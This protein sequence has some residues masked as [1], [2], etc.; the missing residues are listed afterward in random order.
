MQ[1]QFRAIENA[2]ISLILCS[3]LVGGCNA[4]QGSGGVPTPEE[5]CSS[6]T[7]YDALT[8]ILSTQAQSA[9]SVLG[10]DPQL[11]TAASPASLKAVLSYAS[12]TVED[13]NAGTGKVGCKALLRLDTPT[14]ALAQ[15]PG[16]SPN[17]FGP[18]H[19]TYA[20]SYTVQKTADRGQPLMTLENAGSLAAVAFQASIT[21]LRRG[22]D[23]TAQ[24]PVA[25]DDTAIEDDRGAEDPEP[26]AEQ[27][28]AALDRANA[29]EPAANSDSAAPP[30]ASPSE[31][32]PQ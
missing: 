11:T 14:T 13:I 25:D 28:Q 6:Q 10:N 29:M 17:D 7:T 23:A 30:P 27:G 32:K 2:G 9:A 16:L 15:Q 8:G 5:T 21:A 19:V 20:I 18:D 31:D 26:T 22:G 1:R 4:P 24:P 3:A 12:P